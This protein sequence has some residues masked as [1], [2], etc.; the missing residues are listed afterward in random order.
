[1]FEGETFRL[2]VEKVDEWEERGV[3]DCEDL[4]EGQILLKNLWKFCRCGGDLR[5]KTCI[6]CS[7][8]LEVSFRQRR[9]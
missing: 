3:D 5:R 7:G 4:G 2:W 6:R 8:E 9:S 1:M